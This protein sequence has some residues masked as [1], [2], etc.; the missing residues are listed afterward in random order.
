[1][2]LEPLNAAFDRT[3]WLERSTVDSVGRTRWLGRSTLDG[4]GRKVGRSTFD[5][6]GRTR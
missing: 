5:S 4:V 1:M 3:R 6:V 2:E